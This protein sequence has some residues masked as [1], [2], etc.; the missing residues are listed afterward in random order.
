MLARTLL[1]PKS[2]GATKGRRSSEG[3]KSAGAVEQN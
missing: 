3:A 1:A 2:H